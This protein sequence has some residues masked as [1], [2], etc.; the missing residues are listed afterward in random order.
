MIITLRMLLEQIEEQ[1]NSIIREKQNHEQKMEEMKKK[2]ESLQRT[3]NLFLTAN[4]DHVQTAEKYIAVRGL[5]YFG[6]GSTEKALQGV[7]AD[8]LGG[9]KQL[10]ERCFGCKNYYDFICQRCDIEYGY[11]PKHGTVVFKICLNPEYRNEAADEIPEEAI[12][13]IL[14]Y[15]TMIQE[16]E[17]FR[18]AVG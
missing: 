16:S 8:V 10:R 5:S 7:I 9:F 2:L 12:E 11:Q 17:Q 6:S 18:K 13:S 4:I 1:E 14:Y 15:L 3:K